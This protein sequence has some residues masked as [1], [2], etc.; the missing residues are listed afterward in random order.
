MQPKQQSLPASIARISSNILTPSLSRSTSGGLAGSISVCMLL[1]QFESM[2]DVLYIVTEYANGGTL[3]SLINQAKGPLP[4]DVIWR[5]F[6]Q[7]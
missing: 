4:E 6:I 3:H 5:L 7:A 2:Q 1:K